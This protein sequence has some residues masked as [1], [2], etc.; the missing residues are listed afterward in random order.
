MLHCWRVPLYVADDAVPARYQILRRSKIV[1][2]SGRDLYGSYILTPT[3]F[4]SFQHSQAWQSRISRLTPVIDTNEVMASTASEVF[5]I[6]LIAS[7]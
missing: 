7:I 3:T 4:V 6:Q 1:S 5:P 2:T